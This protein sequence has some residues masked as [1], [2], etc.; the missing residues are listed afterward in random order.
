MT[1]LLLL[2]SLLCAA[3]S[4]PLD[5][6]ARIDSCGECTGAAD[7]F[8]YRC[9]W[10]GSSASCASEQSESLCHVDDMTL[11]KYNCPGNV[12][13]VRYDESFMRQ[14]VLPL[15][16]ATHSPDAP[17]LL[18]A[19][20]SCFHDQ[21]EIINSYEI[22][23]EDT[24]VTTCFG[25]SAYLKDRNAL[26]LAFRGT[27]TLFQLIDEGISFFLHPKVEF[28]V[29]E[30]VVDS[31]YLNAFYK[32]WE[33]GMRNDVE[34][35]MREKEDVK[36]W[37][38]GHSLGGGLASI[39]SSYVAKTYGLDTNRSKLVTFGMP[40]IGDID[41]AQA[42]D[43]LVPDSWRIEHSK[44][45][46][47]A[48]PPRTFPDNIDQ[49]SFHHKAEIWY[50]LGMAQGASFQ[51]GSRPDTTVGRSVFPFNIEDHF[52]YFD[53]LLETWYLKGCNREEAIEK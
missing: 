8:G 46:V 12:S 42:H 17:H 35:V 47:P 9:Q 29:T 31:Y 53:V 20:E 5:S 37:F 39:A 51:V 40:R 34:K 30:G 23:C 3:H 36:F 27:T 22:F 43:E 2:L 7:G 44:D 24:E 13:D 10:C 1:K 48:L 6:C 15:I 33:K 16:A 21:I 45:P 32:L 49:G 11:D 14:T 25:Y 26:V 19:L 50:P 38:F 28:N 18:S 41:L 52:T 4:A